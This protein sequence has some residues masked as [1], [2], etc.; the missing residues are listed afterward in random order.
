MLGKPFDYEQE[1]AEIRAEFE[2]INRKLEQT[3][4]SKQANSGSSLTQTIQF[5][6]AAPRRQM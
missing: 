1:L 6:G 2:R 5:V 4:F 3:Q